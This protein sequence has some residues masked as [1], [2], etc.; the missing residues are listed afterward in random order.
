MLKKL[1]PLP[2]RDLAA[3]YKNLLNEEDIQVKRD[4]LKACLNE[5]DPQI[6]PTLLYL[7]LRLLL[8]IVFFALSVTLVPLDKILL[9]RITLCCGVAC[10]TLFTI[11]NTNIWVF[12][13]SSLV[14][15]WL[16]THDVGIL[17][18]GFRSQKILSSLRY[19]ASPFYLVE[20]VD[21]LRG[22][23]PEHKEVLG[24]QTIE[25]LT[26][27]LR[28]YPSRHRDPFAK[29]TRWNKG[30]WV[31]TYTELI[32]V[33]C[34]LGNDTSLRTMRRLAKHKPQTSAEET[35]QAKL[36]EAIP[37]LEARLAL[38]A[39]PHTLLRA[40]SAETLTSE[41]LRPSTH[42]ETPEEELLRPT[43]EKPS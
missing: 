13:K 36:Q 19:Y 16:K 5:I 11:Y 14:Q 12:F 37:V 6:A 35:L 39:Q 15:Q 22:V 9:G 24:K 7:S 20:Y 31:D 23:S 40:S 27:L 33:L 34:L 43:Q 41:L 21:V 25:G 17:S 38:E 26:K 32:R 28:T 3:R 4:G 18:Y 10:W 29:L 2:S 8:C 42:Q 1:F 30:L